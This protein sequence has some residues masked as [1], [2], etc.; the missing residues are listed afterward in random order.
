MAKKARIPATIKKSVMTRFTCCVACGTWDAKA[1]GHIVAESNGGA[2]VAENFV[3]LCH[4]C[5]GVQ[6]NK[7]VTF[8]AYAEYTESRALAE[9][10]RAYWAKYLGAVKVSKGYKPA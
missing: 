10:R 2:M 3:R 8:L 9:S 1:C 7:N 4:D 6:G 5:N